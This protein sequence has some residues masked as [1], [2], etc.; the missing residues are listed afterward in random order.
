MDF[1]EGLPKSK[2]VDTIL[3]VVDRLS[4]YGHF[5][6]LKHLFSASNVASVLIKEIVKLHGF[7]TTIVSDCDKVFMSLFWKDLFVVQGTKLCLSTASTTN[8][9]DR[10][11]W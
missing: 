1:V 5:I 2:G 11:R 9:M 4:K 10:R 7:P 8:R 3:V 6:L